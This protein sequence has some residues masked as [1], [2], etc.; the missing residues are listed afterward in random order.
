MRFTIRHGA[1][2]LLATLLAACDPAASFEPQVNSDS[3]RFALAAANVTSV[4][5]S[6]TFD[7]VNPATSAIV[8]DSTTTTSEGCASVRIY[9]A[10]GTLVY[11]MALLPRFIRQTAT[12]VAGTWTI[13]VT[14]TGYSG[15]VN[16]RLE[17][18]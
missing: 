12:G 16:F 2:V 18:M 14:M 11:S 15:T 3:R 17:P 8:R 4:T 5:S 9:D 10:T 1:V 7:W 13:E 6:F